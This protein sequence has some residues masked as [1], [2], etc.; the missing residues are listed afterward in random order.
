MA[1]DN[2]RRRLTAHYGSSARLSSSAENGLFTTY[3][4]CPLMV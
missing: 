1:L 2:I 4:F 3:I